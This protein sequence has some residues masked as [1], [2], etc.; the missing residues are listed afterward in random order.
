[1]TP[2]KDESRRRLAPS[3][4]LT[5][6]VAVQKS[7][8]GAFIGRPRLLCCL[9]PKWAAAGAAESAAGAAESAAVAA[10]AA[11]CHFGKLRQREERGRGRE[12]DCRAGSAFCAPWRP[13]PLCS[14]SLCLSLSFSRLLC[15][16]I[17]SGQSGPQA[18]HGDSLL[19]HCSLWSGPPMSYPVLCTVFGLQ[20]RLQAPCNYLW[21]FKYE[22]STSCVCLPGALFDW[23]A[24][25]T[26]SYSLFTLS[27]ILFYLQR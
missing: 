5:I 12:W 26:H 10:A 24:I 21:H 19:A 23:H 16:K 2:K 3:F 8:L 13:C 6:T 15:A 14:L 1:M 18:R 17:V 9:K 27:R 11:M 20:N 4:S 7:A 25:L 22:K